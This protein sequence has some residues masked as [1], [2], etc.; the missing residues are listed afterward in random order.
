MLVCKSLTK[1]QCFINL[2]IRASV[3]NLSKRFLSDF[4]L[5]IKAKKKFQFI[6]LKLLN[7][8]QKHNIY[9]KPG[10]FDITGYY[11]ILLPYIVF[12]RLNTN[13]TPR[14]KEWGL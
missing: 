11:H 5:L 3:R 8:E 14:T 12:G 13:Y 4:S 1:I 7:F 6:N 2:P 9:R 10:D